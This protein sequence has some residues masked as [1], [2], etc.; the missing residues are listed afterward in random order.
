MRIPSLDIRGSTGL[1]QYGGRIHE[2]FLKRLQGRRAAK[3]YKEMANNNAI[4]SA[5]LFAMQTLVR[6]VSWPVK[7]AGDSPEQAKEAEFLEGVLDDM[8]M[9][10][11]D[12]IS[13]ALS[14]LIFGW[15]YLEIVWKIRRGESK[16]PRF[17]SQHDDGRIGVRKLEI[18]AQETL[19]RWQFNEEDDGLEGMWQIAPSKPKAVF[20]PIEKAVLYR[21]S[22]HKANPEGKSILRGSYRSWHFLKRI[23]E[24]EAIGIERNMAGVPRVKVPPRML[25]QNP[26]AGDATL[27]A[28]LQ[29]LVQEVRFDERAGLIVPSDVDESGNPTGYDFDL[30]SASGRKTID[31]NLVIERYERRIASSVL[32]DFITASDKVG[33][34][35]SLKAKHQFFGVAL[36]AILDVV[37][38]ITNR[39]LV[40]PL[41]RLNGVPRENWATIEHGDIGKPELSEVADFVSRLAPVGFLTPSNEV[42][43]KLRQ[44]SDLPLEDEEGMGQLMDPSLVPG[45]GED[46]LPPEAVLGPGG[47]GE[48]PDVAKTGLNGAQ[49]TAM[50]D[51]V[52]QV[53]EGR[54]PK[55]SAVGLITVSFP[56]ITTEQAKAIIQPIQATRIAEGDKGEIGA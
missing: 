46:G 28:D 39:F 48:G 36:T 12:V 49:I 50:T 41:Y 21:T 34:Y 44:M 10:W 14:M 55:E 20:I 22:T 31:T 8:S 54:I 45:G 17:R 38:D 35:A 3:I 25:E 15:A 32:A 1:R 30:I 24:F 40:A 47:P 23:Q 42:E 5:I 29:E 6:G 2:E 56:T 7:P 33:V 26:S 19:D 18:R 16:D 37:S 27:L 4:I 52:G 51:I 53:G 43:S 11:Q 9:T 13:E